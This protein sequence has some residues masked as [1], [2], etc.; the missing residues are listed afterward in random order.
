MAVRRARPPSRS[1]RSA[2]RG[3]LLPAVVAVGIVVCD[4]GLHVIALEPGR[5]TVQARDALNPSGLVDVVH[6]HGENVIAG[7]TEHTGLEHELPGECPIVL[8]VGLLR[9][10]SQ[11]A[12]V[13]P[14]PRFVVDAPKEKLES[15]LIQS[16]WGAEAKPVPEIAVVVLEF[17]TRGFECPRHGNGR[18]G[19]IVEG[20]FPPLGLA[21]DPVWILQ[22][23]PGLRQFDRVRDRNR[24]EAGQEGVLELGTQVREA[25]GGSSGGQLWGSHRNYQQID[26]TD[27]SAGHSGGEFAV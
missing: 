12:V 15:I 6:E 1:S 9:H 5:G 14:D 26:L 24:G 10:L 8:R 27:I 2:A 4:R 23:H 11:E 22:P 17:G 16:F 18:P 21:S 3:S 7:V 13:E 19:G 20:S 25:L